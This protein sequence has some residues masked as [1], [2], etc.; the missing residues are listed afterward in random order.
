MSLVL[1]MPKQNISSQI[2]INYCSQL[3]ARIDKSSKSTAPL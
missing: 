1:T 3:T 2:R